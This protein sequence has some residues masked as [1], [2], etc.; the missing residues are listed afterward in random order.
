MKIHDKPIDNSGDPQILVAKDFQG[1]LWLRYKDT[2]ASGWPKNVEVSRDRGRTWLNTPRIG[3][4]IK[5][6]DGCGRWVKSKH[7]IK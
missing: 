2:F 5:I 1:D 3:H 4:A 6:R 7:L